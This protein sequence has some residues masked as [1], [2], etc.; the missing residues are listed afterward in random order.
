MVKFYSDVTNKFYEDVSA[1]KEAEEKLKNEKLKREELKKQMA[2]KV[3]KTRQDLEGVRKE[4]RDIIK[5]A[6][7]EYN[8]ALMNYCKEFGE[9]RYQIQDDDDR[10]DWIWQF[11]NDWTIR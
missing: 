6:E 3:E 9:Y 11:L 7:K 10:L 8:E 4:Y 2:E 1:A 5:N